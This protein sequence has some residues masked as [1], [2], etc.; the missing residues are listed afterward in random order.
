MFSERIRKKLEQF[1]ESFTVNGATYRGIFRILDASTANAYLDDTERMAVAKPGL[2]LVTDSSAV[3]SSGNTLTRDGRTY[4][5]LKTSISRIGTEA[6]V[7]VAI[8]N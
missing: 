2:M 6:V 4:T 8:L 7:R 1:G 5:V 3:I